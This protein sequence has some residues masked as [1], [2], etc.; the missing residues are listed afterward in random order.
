MKPFIF[1]IAICIIGW[2]WWK[3]FQNT[4]TTPTPPPTPEDQLQAL[5][6]GSPVD[7]AKLAALCEQFPQKANTIL[8]GRKIKVIGTIKRL[9]VRGIDSADLDIDLFGT[10]RFN[11]VF[12]T[13]N[14]RYNTEHTG[15]Q[16]Y[17]YKFVKSRNRLLKYSFQQKMDG[18]NYTTL[19]RVIY[20][21]GEKVT[22]EGFIEA[23]GPTRIKIHY[24]EGIPN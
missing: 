21:E 4:P 11:V 8:K 18:G 10:S 9:L 20:T 17:G 12:S 23:I 7:A 22:L 13:D 6:G 5:L 2:G 3:V 1:L 15:Y 19:D 16:G 24:A 14:S